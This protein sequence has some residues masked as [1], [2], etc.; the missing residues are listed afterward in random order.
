MPDALAA[1]EKA[2]DAVLAALA[3]IDEIE[4]V[5]DEANPVLPEG[6][7]LLGAE[8]S[9]RGLPA[10]PRTEVGRRVIGTFWVFA[11]NGTEVPQRL[12]DK[13]EADGDRGTL[14]IVDFCTAASSHT[15]PEIAERD[16]D[17]AEAYYPK[18]RVA[19]VKRRRVE[20]I[21]DEYRAPFDPG[22][23]R[24]SVNLPSVL[25]PGGDR[26]PREKFTK[27][28][29]EDIVPAKAEAA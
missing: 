12:A 22:S 2:A 7:K 26:M 21:Y 24:H 5:V 14:E 6:E 20:V 9:Y 18:R 29:V 23:L 13:I 4:A 27:V 28:V 8:W 3:Q 11:E 15:L 16:R 25:P 1:Y 19:V 17:T 10:K